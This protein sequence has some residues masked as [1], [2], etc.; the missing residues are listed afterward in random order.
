MKILEDQQPPGG[1]DGRGELRV[2][3]RPLGVCGGELLHQAARPRLRPLSPG[4]E[5][6]G[7]GTGDPAAHP[8][9]E[10]PGE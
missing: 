7:R 5:A 3:F 9:G 2:L 10:H 6:R 4:Q 1:R 8:R